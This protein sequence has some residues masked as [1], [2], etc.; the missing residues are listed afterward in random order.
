MLAA[1]RIVVDINNVKLPSFVHCWIHYLL[2]SDDTVTRLIWL[3][4]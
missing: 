1:L 4:H 3:F 2:I